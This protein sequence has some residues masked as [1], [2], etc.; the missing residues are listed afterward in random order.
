MPLATIPKY[1]VMPN[2]I[3]VWQGDP[4]LIHWYKYQKIKPPN[5]LGFCHVFPILIMMFCQRKTIQTNVEIVK[6]DPVT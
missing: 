2:L 6:Y 4:I 5:Y 1:V 3:N